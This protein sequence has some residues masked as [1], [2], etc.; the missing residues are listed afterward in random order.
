MGKIKETVISNS[1]ANRRDTIF[2][3]RRVQ[4]IISCFNRTNGSVRYFFKMHDSQ[5]DDDLWHYCINFSF[6]F[7]L[8]S[9]V[10]SVLIFTL[11]DRVREPKHRELEFSSLLLLSFFTIFIFYNC[12]PSFPFPFRLWANLLFR[13][14]SFYLQCSLYNS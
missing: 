11:N 8:F 12:P 13:C 5:Y 10:F 4:L 3:W 6:F 14:S 1:P 2:H 9:F 7:F